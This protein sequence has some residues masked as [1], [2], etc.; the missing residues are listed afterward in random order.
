MLICAPE[1]SAVRYGLMVGIDH[2]SPYYGPPD[3]GSCI[4]DAN[5]FRDCLTADAARWQAGNIATLTDGGATKWAIRNRMS[6]MAAMAVAGDVVVYLHSSHGGSHGG[7]ATFI[8]SYDANYEDYELAADLSAFATGVKVI[9]IVDA[10]YAS[11]LY[12]LAAGAAPKWNFVDDVTRELDA[13]RQARGIAK[14]ADIGWLAACNYYEL[15]WAGDP[16]SLFAGYVID[17]FTPGDA[18]HDGNLTFMELY[19]Y[20]APLTLAENPSQ[21]AQ[22]LNDAL[23]SGTV[24]AAA[25]SLVAIGPAVDNT[26]LPWT[27]GGNASWYGQTGVSRHDGDAARSGAI[28]SSQQ[29]WMQTTVTG[30]GTLSFWWKVSSEA[31]YDVLS[32]RVDSVQQ[33]GAAVSGNVDWQLKSYT[34]PSGTHDCRWVYSKDSSM[35]GGSDAAW[36][37]RVMWAG[38]DSCR[39]SVAFPNRWVA[40]RVWDASLSQW[41]VSTN[42]YAPATIQT[43]ALATGRWYWIGMWDYSI[44]AW[45]YGDWF[46]RM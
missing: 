2:Y 1:A 14:G 24:A 3:L 37:D 16:Y 44:S 10:C 45:V 4:N 46:T 15:S 31:G 39:W 28:G 21:H 29:T 13:V 32:F 25:F 36:V 42:R 22:R 8:C 11:G 7:T 26:T 12:Q 18:N 41:V 30:P 9:V 43:P 38:P 27:T 19:N 40:V 6:Q 17:A 23:L 35:S 33:P 5:G 20:A 34:I